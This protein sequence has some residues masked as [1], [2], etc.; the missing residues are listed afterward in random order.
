MAVSECRK[1]LFN[2]E[3][4]LVHMKFSIC[5]VDFLSLF[6]L[7]RLKIIFD[8]V[9]RTSASW[10]ILGISMSKIDPY[11]LNRTLQA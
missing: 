1:N 6:T 7:D 4:L 9:P 5:L 3:R 10:S 11:L 2:L 8:I